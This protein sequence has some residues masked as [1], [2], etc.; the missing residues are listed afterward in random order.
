NIKLGNNVLRLQVVYGEGIQNYMNDADVDV[1]IVPN[2]GNL[3]Q[4]LLGEALPMIGVVAFIDVN[5]SSKW[6]STFGYSFLDNDNSSGQP[7]SAYKKGQ[8]ALANLLY[9][10]TSKVLMGPELQWGDREN[11]NDGFS[12]DDVRIQFSAR[13]DFGLSV[14][15]GG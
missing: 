14:G 15:G 9:H 4:P 3:V 10:P 11:F 12:S 5:W 1:G 2:P 13:Y 8:Y 7:A 6:T